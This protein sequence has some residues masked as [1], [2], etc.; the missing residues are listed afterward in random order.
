M[1]RYIYNIHIIDIDNIQYI[2]LRYIVNNYKSRSRSYK[3]KWIETCPSRE[4]NFG[5]Q[6]P[7]PR[8]RNPKFCSGECCGFPDHT[9]RAKKTQRT[10]GILSQGP[11]PIN[12][13]CWF[14]DVLGTWLPNG[15]EDTVILFLYGFGKFQKNSVA[16]IFHFWI[17]YDLMRLTLW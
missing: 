2:K 3:Y 6:S 1:H 12:G 13:P 7:S 10:H 5:S 9:T 15:K 14:L 11:G 8:P 17:L 16:T 4:T